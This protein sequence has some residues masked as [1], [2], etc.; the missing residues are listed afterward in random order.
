MFGVAPHYLVEGRFIKNEK[1]LTTV[2]SKYKSYNS[3]HFHLR[4][5]HDLEEWFKTECG[6]VDPYDIDFKHAFYNDMVGV[7]DFTRYPKRNPD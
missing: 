7:P 1:D 6:L 4:T 3:P 2:N 5:A